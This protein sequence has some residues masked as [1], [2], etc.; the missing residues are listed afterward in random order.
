VFKKDEIFK[1]M[2]GVLFG[3]SKGTVLAKKKRAEE[4]LQ[5][6]RRLKT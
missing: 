5:K 4:K 3:N 1:T 6:L 2:K